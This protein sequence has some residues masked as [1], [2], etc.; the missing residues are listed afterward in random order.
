MVGARI[1]ARWFAP[2][3][4]LDPRQYFCPLGSGLWYSSSVCV[5]A[6]RQPFTALAAMG[7]RR[8]RDLRG[9]RSRRD[10]VSDWIVPPLV[11]HAGSHH[12]NGRGTPAWSMSGEATSNHRV[13]RL[14]LV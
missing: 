2:G 14:T 8:I 4:E 13:A 12:C 1:S 6:V 10:C 7:S 9:F 3:V 11:P 5:F